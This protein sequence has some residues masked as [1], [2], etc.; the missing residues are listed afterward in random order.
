MIL[1][2]RQRETAF[3]RSF[4]VPPVGA[5]TKRSIICKGALRNWNG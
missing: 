2:S 4:A 3:G 1:A 5:I